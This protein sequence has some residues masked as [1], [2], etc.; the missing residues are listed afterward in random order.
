MRRNE[1]KQR[2]IHTM[3]VWVG[4]AGSDWVWWLTVENAGSGLR[5]VFKTGV[6]RKRNAGVKCL[7]GDCACC[8]TLRLMPSLAP[9][10]TQEMGQC[11]VYP[12]FQFNFVGPV[13]SRWG[14]VFALVDSA[15]IFSPLPHT[16]ATALLVSQSYNANRLGVGLLVA[17]IDLAL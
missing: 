17:S 15:K 16:N 4:S 12:T 5:E 7:P 3:R 2:K 9:K 10:S 6:K 1:R 8:G 14:S 11:Q 13:G